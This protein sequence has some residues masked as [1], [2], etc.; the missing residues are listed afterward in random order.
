MLGCGGRLIF[1]GDFDLGQPVA[2]GL[3]VGGL[4][5]DPID[6][7]FGEPDDLWRAV[8]RDVGGVDA[9]A[10]AESEG[11]LAQEVVRVRTIA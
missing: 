1:A 11:A 3:V 8:V 7:F 5:F 9:A 4:E 6:G 2:T 10:I